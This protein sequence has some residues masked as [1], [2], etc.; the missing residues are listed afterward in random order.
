MRKY[1]IIMVLLLIISFSSIAAQ[2]N[3]QGKG[4]GQDKNNQ[5]VSQNSISQYSQYY[6]MPSSAA[7]ST[8][9]VAPQ[10][11]SIQNMPTT[12]Y[13]GYQMQAIPYT[14]YQTYATYTGGNSLWI[15]G[16]TSWTQYAA[17]PQ[18]A[19]LSLLATTSA[20]GDG[21]LYE[22]TP[23]GQLTK[24]YY[25][26]FTGYNQLNFYADTVG[27]HILLFAID[28]QVSNAAVINVVANQPPSYSQ[29]LN[30]NQPPSY[31]QL[32]SYNQ[33]PAYQHQIYL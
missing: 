21:Y 31:N 9:I 33:P 17:I 29:P 22:I 5:K 11:Y 32:P 14:Q 4:K 20:G 19:A 3:G 26:F 27:Q 13:F 2:D 18:G 24:N 1:L 16:S 6:V 30:Y 23:D 10:K 28:N 8:H 25:S 7:P 12:L 15:Q